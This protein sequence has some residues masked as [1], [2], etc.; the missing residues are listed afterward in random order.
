LSDTATEKEPGQLALN[1]KSRL[2]GPVVA[3]CGGVG[4]AK[5]ALG[6]E[7][8]LEPG[9]LSIV[10]NTGDDFEHL[11]LHISPDIDTVT[12]TLADLNNQELGWGR[13]NETWAFMKALRA[14]G[15]EA[16]FSLGDSDLATHIERT[17][18]LRS[19]EQLSEVTAAFA[20]HL[21]ISAKLLPMTDSRL[22]T[23][24]ETNEGRL[25]FQDYFVRRQSEPSI[26]RVDYDGMDTAIAGA[27]VL[28]ALAQP[29][30]RAI[31]ICPSNP[32][33]SIAPILAV[34]GIKDAIKASDA[35]VV[36]VSPLIA[37]QAVKGPT[38]KIMA[39]LSLPTTARAIA[40]Y[41]GDLLDGLIIDTAD[42]AQTENFPIPVV[43]VQTLMTTL[44]DREK[45]ALAT[46]EFAVT[47]CEPARS[48]KAIVR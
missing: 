21:G 12:Y 31:V 6:L 4:G 8:I 16:W 26:E 17:R 27:G 11:G 2:A 35:P 32:F 43:A 19:G 15:G 5:L 30:L 3:L 7:H 41:Y 18:R 29:G 9:D 20:T 28:A 36:C 24:L 25:A 1:T 22:R 38:A 48:D 46:L 10:I 14:L 34:P 33:L 42:S 39:E 44:E 37:G 45:L 47:L 23:V 13:Q 40:D